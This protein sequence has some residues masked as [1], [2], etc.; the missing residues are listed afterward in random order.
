MIWPWAYLEVGLC[1]FY[2][3]LV[4]ER[5]QDRP[6]AKLAAVDWWIY[7]GV[8][9]FWPLVVAFYVVAALCWLLDSGFRK[10]MDGLKTGLGVLHRALVVTGDLVHA[11]LTV[12][13]GP[14]KSRREA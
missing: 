2:F 12:E 7:V 4:A 6:P 3:F 9:V 5:L 13:L 10:G 11:A 14:G 1:I 8:G